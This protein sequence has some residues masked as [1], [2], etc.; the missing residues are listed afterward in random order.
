MSKNRMINTKYWN[1]GFIINLNPTQKLLFI[2]FLTNQYTNLCGVYECNTKIIAFE[3]GINEKLIEKIFKEFEGKIHYIK[4]WV[5]VRNFEKHQSGNDKMKIG[6]DRERKEIPLNIRKEILEIDKQ[7]LESDKEIKT[8]EEELEKETKKLKK[9]KD[10]IDKQIDDLI[11]YYKEIIYPRT[12][13]T[14]QSRDKIRVRLM[15]KST[16]GG[17]TRFE[18]L[19]LAIDNFSKDSWR[20]QNNSGL[21]LQFFFRSEDQIVKWLTLDIKVNKIHKIL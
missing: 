17:V 5:Y 4:G 1:D 3:T 2:Y 21:G 15:E 13:A 11:S 14:K 19:K 12:K 9:N 7:Y 6:A 10:I 20:M 8:L 18:E 16:D